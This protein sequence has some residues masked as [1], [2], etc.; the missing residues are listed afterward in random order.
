MRM[1]FF[2]LPSDFLATY[3]DKIKAVTIEDV[4]RSMVK[5][6]DPQQMLRVEVGENTS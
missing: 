5:Q 6:L 1:Y 4:R 3:R 2:S